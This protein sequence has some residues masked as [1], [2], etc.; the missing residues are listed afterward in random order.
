MSGDHFDLIAQEIIRQKQ[1]MDLLIAEN[2]ELQQ[3]IA[4]LRSGRGIFVE[5]LGQRFALHDNTTYPQSAAT[6]TTG[7]DTTRLQPQVP[8]TPP[9]TPTQA[10]IEA[11]TQEIAGPVGQYSPAHAFAQAAPTDSQ[12]P[13]TGETTFLEEIMIDEFA[14]ALTTPRAVWQDP[15][16]KHKTNKNN[17]TNKTDKQPM[18]SQEPINEQ[19]KAALRRELMGSFL[20]E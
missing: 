11:P 18:P 2:R 10:V 1:I 19:Q 15:A 8:S 20:L 6:S 13:A 14:N 5:I 7:R 4:D 16:E 17:K 12:P 9:A 3:Q